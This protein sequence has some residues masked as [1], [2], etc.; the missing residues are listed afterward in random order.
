M[1]FVNY[2]T[3]LPEFKE[4][5]DEKALKELISSVGGKPK[6]ASSSLDVVSHPFMEAFKKQASLTNTTNGALTYN[7]TEDDCLNLFYA[8]EN[9]APRDS[10]RIF[11]AAWDQDPLVTLKIIFYA[12][13]IHHG[14][15]D[16]ESFYVAFGWLLRNHPQTA[17]INLPQLINPTCRTNAEL[18]RKKKFNKNNKDDWV[19][20]EN[21]L[22]DRVDFKTHGYWKD[23]AN[24][25]VI[26]TQGEFNTPPTTKMDFKALRWPRM[27]KSKT[28]RSSLL[29]RET[30]RKL[31]LSM[32]PENRLK[33][34]Q[35]NIQLDQENAKQAKLDAQQARHQVQADRNV[36]VCQLLET[37]LVYRCLH[38]SIARLF[39]VQLEKDMV[40][41]EANKAAVLAGER[42]GAYALGF[43]LSLAAKWAPSLGH[44]HDK[45]TFLATSIAECLFSNTQQ[46]GESRADY[47]NRARELYRMKYLAP[48]RKAIDLIEHRMHQGAWETV[49][50]RH[51]PSVCLQNTMP[52][53][54]LHAP[55][56]VVD[57]M[58]SVANG[59]KKISG[60]TLGPHE[61]VFKVRVGG[62]IDPKLERMFQI[63]PELRQ[64]FI[65]AERNMVNGQ[66]DTLIQ[67]IRETA[68]LSTDEKNESK[69]KKIDLGDCIAICDVS[70]SMMFGGSSPETAPLNA[71]IG[72]SLVVTNLAKPP[73]NGALIT[74]SHDPKLF[75]I[76]TTKTFAEQVNEVSDSEMGYN[77]D[78]CAVFT[79]VLLPMAKRHNLK[80]EDMVKRMFIFTDME[81]DS[82]H[83]GM[84]TY[85][86]THEFIKKEYQDAGYELPELVWWNLCSND[87]Y[88]S[89][90]GMITPVQKDEAGV[91]LLAGF[92]SSM[93]KTFLE[94]DVDEDEDED[95]GESLDSQAQKPIQQKTKMTPIDFMLRAVH[96]ES[97]KSLIVVD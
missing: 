19:M 21:Q 59:T 65:G 91:S 37:D 78:I 7:T 46:D 50:F 82:E 68:L 69:K 39:A 96:H 81:F 11:Q 51:A 1:S 41:L 30:R 93:I 95:E 4:L 44:S 2:P 72:L 12:R 33:D 83:N 80:Q 92:S 66:W 5:F 22:L 27:P 60:A 97:F 32:T 85:L 10:D 57:Y 29:Q 86:T 79:K 9:V 15:S 58:D 54:F 53:F 77:T 24:I 16:R 67:S 61:L 74:F 26:Y 55:D 88:I 73:F 34:A 35:L 70:G 20:I 23:L 64:K 76:D 25:L 75:N 28:R 47:L 84:D 17:L 43:N 90:K 48:L 40:Q 63:M 36:K 18:N 87:S 89:R 56:K 6:R 14:K 3:S 49:D 42:K 94:G 31:R 38:L 62:Q 8:I 71:A 52:K 13:S 45:H